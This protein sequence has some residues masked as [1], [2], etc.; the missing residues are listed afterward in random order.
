MHLLE[1]LGY[2]VDETSGQSSSSSLGAGG[3]AATDGTV[4][5]EVMG[6][7]EEIESAGSDAELKPLFDANLQRIERT[8]RA[9][10]AAFEAQDMKKAW[11][12][13]VELQYWNRIDETLR[14]KMDSLESPRNGRLLSIQYSVFGQMGK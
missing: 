11:Q 4:L 10:G 12:L 6:I 14:E 5:M 13:T 3:A 8:C 9:L 2:P 1:L 7:R